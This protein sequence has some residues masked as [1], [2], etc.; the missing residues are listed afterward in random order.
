MSESPATTVRYIDN[1]SRGPVSARL[2]DQHSETLT[3][4]R[5]EV[6]FSIPVCE[7]AES[8]TR[9]HLTIEM[10]SHGVCYSLWID[11]GEVRFSL[12]GTWAR[13]AKSMYGEPTIGGDRQI[14]AEASGKLRI[15]EIWQ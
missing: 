10:Y 15:K 5:S 13:P 11:E 7:D 14:V 9:Q 8:F 2:G 6:S 3:Y 4:Q 1:H 12:D